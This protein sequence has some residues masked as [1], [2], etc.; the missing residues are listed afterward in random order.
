MAFFKTASV[1]V[2]SVYQRSGKFSKCAARFSD[3]PS[4]EDKQ[5]ERAVQLISTES[6]SAV[7]KIYNLSDDI[8]DYIFPVPRCVTANVPNGN[9]DRFTHDELTRF[10]PNHRCQVYATFKNDPLHVEH[11]ADDPK[12]ARGFLPDVAYNTAN[13]DDMHVIAI[14]AIDTTKDPALAQGILDGHIDSFSMGCICGFVKC[15]Y[16]K[17]PHPIAYSDADLC[18]HLRYHKMTTINGELI[19]EDC[20]DVE[21]QE[22]SQVG[23]PADPTALTQFVLQ[24]AARM[25]ERAAAQQAFAPIRTMLSGADQRIVAEYFRRNVNSLPE[26]MIRLADKLF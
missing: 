6:L 8:N 4:E 11:V 10:S 17:C 13:K 18:D 19:F 20:G 24:R 22:L 9:G 3:V 26:A 14:A 23:I 16:S 12:A 2:L 7:A 5:I 1:P 25:Q 21:F 15:S